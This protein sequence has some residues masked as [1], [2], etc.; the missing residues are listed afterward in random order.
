[1]AKPKIFIASSGRTLEI[2]RQL[3]AQLNADYCE[4]EVWTEVSQRK[5]GHF[6]LEVLKEATREYDFAVIILSRDDV[7][8]T[9]TDDT[10]ET[11]DKRKARDNCVFEAGLFIGATG[12]SRC[13]LLTSVA[14]TDLPS[15]LRGIIY[16]PFKEPKDLTDSDECRKAIVTAATRIE[17][18][19][20]KPRSMGNRPL[21]QARL[22]ERER[23]IHQG[24]ELLMDQVVVTSAQPLDLGYNAARQV[25]ENIDNYNI[26]Y[27]YFFQGNKEGAY[28][29][30]ELLQILLLANILKNQTDANN[31]GTRLEEL[32]K[33][34]MVI[35][36]ELEKICKGDMIK[37]FFLPAPPAL[38]F[39]IHNA[40]A[41]RS[42]TLY[43]ERRRGEDQKQQEFIEWESGKG[44]YDFWDEVRRARGAL[45]PNPP[46]AV[47]YG[48]PG[49]D[50]NERTFNSILKRAVDNY[51]PGIEQDVMT[52]CLGSTESKSRLNRK[53]PRGESVKRLKRG[54]SAGTLTGTGQLGAG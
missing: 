17:S 23:S 32:A 42:A 21:T 38:Q 24:G 35:K 20:R 51:F 8:V 10:G 3:R 33:N 11:H 4:P 16:Q 5:M 34:T 44:A 54:P 46:N 28:K 30:C 27:V 39:C 49:F 19:V 6:I 13:L 50:I 41:D 26:R 40:G 53:P 12:E 22:L 36:T 15:D 31:W 52:L 18:E 45:E 47:F 29:T 2:A 43:L 37:I 14:E 25:R 7:M 9:T 1:M 48:V